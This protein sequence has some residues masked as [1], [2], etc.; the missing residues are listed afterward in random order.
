MKYTEEAFYQ[1][2]L[3]NLQV[4]I[5]TASYNRVGTT[6]KDIDFIPDFNRFYFIRS[7]E[8]YLKIGNQEY[9]PLRGQLYILPSHIKQSYSTIN[10]NTFCKYWCHFTATIGDMNL[11]QMLEMPYFVQVED[12]SKLEYLF[13]QLIQFYQKQ[14]L[15][16]QI[17]MKGVMLE[18]IAVFLENHHESEIQPTVTESMQKMNKVM[19]YIEIHLDETIMVE[20]LASLL[21]FHPNYFIHFFKHHIGF[22]PIQYINKLRL[23]KAKHLL[24]SSQKSISEIANSIG[25]DVYY[26]SKFFKQHNGFSPKKYRSFLKK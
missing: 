5:T 26:F 1:H 9:Y 22:S 15:T 21:H 25:M 17:R 18:I 14:D 4:H 11:F 13:E 8:G 16:S 3:A 23:E 10:E 19:E 6:W 12:E 7:G 24:L 2:Y 20:D